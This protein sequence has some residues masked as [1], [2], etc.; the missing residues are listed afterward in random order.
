MRTI[1]AALCLTVAAVPA[2]ADRALLVGLPDGSRL[3]EAFREAGFSVTNAPAD[4]AGDMRAALSGL[5]S[6]ADPGERRVIVL[7]GAFVHDGRA[8]WLLEREEGAAPDRGLVGGVAVSVDTALAIAAGAPGAAFVALA[9][10][11]DS[12]VPELGQG[13]QA[14]LVPPRDVPQGV[15]LLQ[16]GQRDVTELLRRRALRPGADLAQAAGR[17]GGVAALGFLPQGHAIRPEAAEAAAPEE[18]DSSGDAAEQEAW[19]RA[20][21]ADTRTA[22]R[23][24]LDSY[25]EGANADAARE[26]IAA[27]ED[28]PGRMA[29]E[30]EAAL[31]LDRQRRRQVQSQLTILGHEPQGVDG[32][33][34]PNTR[35][36]IARFQR[37]NG[38]RD[39]GYLTREQIDTL[40]VAA[41]QRQAELEA[42]AERRR[43]QAERED[44]AVWQATG[45]EGDEAGLRTYLQRYPDGLFA[46][47]AR[48]ELAAIEG[49]KR[50][51][52]EA[53]DAAAWERA[54][55]ADSV[56]AYRDYL[57][58]RPEG[59]F[60]S[61]ARARIEAIRQE[62]EG[63]GAREQARQQEAQLGLNDVT[64]LLVERRLA[65]LGLDP[66]VSDGA[67]DQSTRQAIRAF[68]RNRD[69]E[70]T[71][72]LNQQTVARMLADLG[73][74]V[75]PQ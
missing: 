6:A 50:S 52:A 20:R 36:A 10:A 51:A 1:A 48:E 27:I 21:E 38:Y 60:A 73:G 44:R 61:E 69:L 31:D 47:E 66:G 55:G 18:S 49:R 16:G 5:L 8:V 59:A 46:E 7:A 62:Q 26:A 2:L 33:F 25:P 14:G 43:I 22:Y 64:R 15:T 13:M 32:V 30:R 57:D 4:N 65:Q 56:T 67:F 37:A 35:S 23:D 53:A 28:D 39:T 24:Y 75:L 74:L 19:G 42:E 72:Y 45:A 29:A 70:P 54:R 9:A 17:T 41:A 63:A 58:A 12:A 34:G 71:G 68:Q 3:P 11:P 40:S